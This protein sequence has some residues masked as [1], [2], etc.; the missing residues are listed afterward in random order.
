MRGRIAQP[1]EPA[2]LSTSTPP[3]RASSLAASR[4]LELQRTAG[5]AAVARLLAPSDRAVA[6]TPASSAIDPLLSYGAFD[7]AVSD[8][9]EESIVA[10]LEADA[11]LSATI[12]D[13]DAAEMLGPLID[14]VD[15]Q[16]RRRRLL[17]LLGRDLEPASRRLVHPHVA[18]LDQ[19]WQVL[20]SLA[21]VGVTSG[22]APFTPTAFHES[23]VGGPTDPFSGVG[24]TGTNPT[25]LDIPYEDQAKL[26][27]ENTIG[28]PGPTTEDYSNP[29]GSLPG[30]LTGLTAAERTGQAELFLAQ[31]ISSV[32]EQV[33]GGEVPSRAQLITAA[34]DL[35]NLEPALV[36][37]FLLAEQRD[38]SRNEDAKDYLAADSMGRNTSIG[39]GQVV[40]STAE[41]NDLFADML[42]SGTRGSLDR[43]EIAELLASD[44]MNI[45]AA[46]RYIRKIAD[47]GS[48]YTAADLPNTVA[49][50]PNVDFAAYAGHSSGWPGDNVRALGSEYTSRAWDDRLVAPWGDFVY[51][52]YRDCLASGAI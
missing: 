51:E 20:F 12:V 37:G 40:I 28:S 27:Y 25:N 52:A 13:L 41:G 33:Y 14:R 36:A 23:L 29:I 50:F 42:Y 39:L 26:A 19:E 35:H 10:E 21:M 48:T 31:Q 46:A 22:A 9:D 24:A 1:R 18:Q 4:V 32:M 5:N 2:A 8:E 7:Y 47:D 45:F 30:Y 49:S 11:S 6:R 15:G 3:R 44:E 16:G 38:Q 17:R 34:A 43:D